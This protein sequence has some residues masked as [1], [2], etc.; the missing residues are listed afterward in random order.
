MKPQGER[1]GFHCLF[2]LPVTLLE[3]AP[4]R[5]M[6]PNQARDDHRRHNHH[7]VRQVQVLPFPHN[8]EQHRQRAA[9][10]GG[11][12]AEGQLRPA[13]HD[14]AEREPRCVRPLPQGFP[15]SGLQRH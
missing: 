7:A 5:A 12:K 6:Q 10:P 11:H 8:P 13:I 3:T 1:L 15:G 9:D 2:E 14:P 4:G